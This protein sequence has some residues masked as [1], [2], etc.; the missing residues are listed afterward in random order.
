MVGNKIASIYYGDDVV[1]FLGDDAHEQHVLI[2]E[3]PK[4]TIKSVLRVDVL[5]ELRVVEHP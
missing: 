5:H 3:E 2:R 4:P 1:V